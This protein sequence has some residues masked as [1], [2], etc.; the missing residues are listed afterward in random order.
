M[1][2]SPNLIYVIAVKSRES[3]TKSW[4]TSNRLQKLVQDPTQS[5]WR[6]EKLAVELL[7]TVGE[8]KRKTRRRPENVAGGQKINEACLAPFLCTIFDGDDN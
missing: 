8:V 3:I 1:T 7:R 2:K 4:L 5:S 6:L